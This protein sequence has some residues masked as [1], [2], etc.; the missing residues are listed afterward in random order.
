MK[1]RRYL[2]VKCKV[3]LGCGHFVIE[4]L[5]L[6]MKGLKRFLYLRKRLCCDCWR[7][8]Q[9]RRKQWIT[10]K[11]GLQKL[12][13]NKPQFV[14]GMML[15]G[16]FALKL[17][18]DGYSERCI[19]KF[20]NSDQSARWWLKNKDDLSSLFLQF[21][22]QKEIEAATISK[23]T[24]VVLFLYRVLTEIQYRLNIMINSIS[25]E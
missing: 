7:A 25:Y 5:P 8:D 3:R 22:I 10:A 14:S 4:K 2:R 16:E 19:T 13:G 11:L 9:H 18:E 20:L 24:G 6:N 21:T 23:K 15:R 12:R 17:M 1:R